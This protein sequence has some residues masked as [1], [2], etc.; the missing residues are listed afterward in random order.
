MGERYL[1]NMM[2]TRRDLQ[3]Q[4]ATPSNLN[5]RS[6]IYKYGTSN[7]DW[8]RWVFDQLELA[9][10]ERVLEI[11]CGDGGLW[12][13]NL[14]RLPTAAAIVLG[15]LSHG[16]LSEGR[17]QLGQFGFV[18]LEAE[19]V[20]FRDAE[21]DV[22]VANHMLYHVENRARTLAE[23]RRVLR[24]GGRL[25]AATNGER[26]VGQIKDLIARFLGDDIPASQPLS[27][28]LENG[29][30]QLSGIFSSVEMQEQPGE[31]RVPDADAIVN[32]VLSVNGAPQKIVGD[33]MIELRR[34]IDHA[35]QRDGAFIVQ[36]HVG[37]FVAAT[38]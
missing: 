24:P 8:S 10:G 27:F 17:A 25:L 13:K 11:G 33:R 28:S 20:P 7:V 15:D 14:D 18:Q 3:Q 30:Q 19:H 38:S 31:L 2:T 26:H 16:M 21:F 23:I 6:A 32:Y 29:A 37:L 36:T 35:M 1:S 9:A 4:Y 5:A 34:T 12:R 22:V